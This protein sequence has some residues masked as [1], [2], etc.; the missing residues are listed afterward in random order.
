MFRRRKGDDQEPTHGRYYLQIVESDASFKGTKK[1]LAAMQK[2]LDAGAARGWALI[3]AEFN[4]NAP[5]VLL[6]DTEPT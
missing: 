4:N 3:Q 1:H 6:W 2:E 5:S